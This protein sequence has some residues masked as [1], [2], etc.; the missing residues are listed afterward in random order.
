M[1]S[2]LFLLCSSRFLAPPREGR[3]WRPPGNWVLRACL[4]E[5]SATTA[6]SRAVGI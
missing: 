5:Q 4:R 1:P 2:L 6:G 3:N